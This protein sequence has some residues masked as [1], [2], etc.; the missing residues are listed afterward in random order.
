MLAAWAMV[1]AAA[2]AAHAQTGKVVLIVEENQ[3]FPSIVGTSQAP[4]VNQLIANGK[5]FTKYTAAVG[6]S[7]PN[8]L[9]MTSGAT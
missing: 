9:A 4:Y 7:N 5:L 6:S 1:L 8:Y 3:P 2:G